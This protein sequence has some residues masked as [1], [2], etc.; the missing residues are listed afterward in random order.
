MPYALR[1]GS[2][3]PLL[4][5]VLLLCVVPVRAQEWTR[6]RGPNGT[7]V[8][9]AKSIPATWTDADYRWKIK[10]PGKGHGSPVV[11]GDRLFLLS[12]DPHNATRYVICVHTRVPAKFCGSASMRRPRIR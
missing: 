11:W 12:A 7:G 6:F 3:L 4:L 5:P 2:P 1:S 8:S 10:L 9:D